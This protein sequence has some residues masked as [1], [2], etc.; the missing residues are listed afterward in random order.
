MLDNQ[1]L[2]SAR[3]A[4]NV[5][6]TPLKVVRTTLK[7][8]GTTLEAS[9]KMLEV[10]RTA[11][12]SLRMAL[13]FARTALN[14]QRIAVNVS[15]MP[16]QVSRAMLEVER[17]TQCLALD[18]PRLAEPWLQHRRRS[19]IAPYQRPGNAAGKTTLSYRPSLSLQIQSFHVFKH[20]AGGRLEL[21]QFVGCQFQFDDLFNAVLAK[22]ARYADEHVFHAVL[23]RAP[24]CTR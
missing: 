6:R 10:V 1:P 19:A 4:L 8:A 23:A 17:T 7:V 13:K 14:G 21:R 20:V 18:G 15:G 12:D 5:A 2:H 9:R 11:L 22:H 3:T 24:R 16:L